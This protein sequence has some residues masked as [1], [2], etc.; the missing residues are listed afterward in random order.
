MFNYTPQLV[1]GGNINPYSVVKMSTTAWTG[2]ASSA[3]ADFVVGVSDGSTRRFDSAYHA[4]AG[5]P[6]SLQPSPT[7]QVVAASTVTS[8]NIT[9]GDGLIVDTTDTNGSVS[10][11]VG[12]G[13]GTIPMFVA[14][15]S[16]TASGQVFWAYRLGSV[17]GTA[18]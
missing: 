6:I 3:N 7:V 13:A 11:A 12:A 9:A 8:T 10:K 2:A 17:K 5:D 1:A 14:L 15:E 16:A 18:S 4:I